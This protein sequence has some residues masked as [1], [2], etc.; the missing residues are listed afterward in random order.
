MRRAALF[1]IAAL[2]LLAQNDPVRGKEIVDKAITALGG[3][4]FL[5]M[6]DRTER[7]RAYSFYHEQLSGLSR[8]VIYTRYLTRPEPPQYGFIGLRE[9]QA[10]GKKEDVYIVF[11]EDGGH[12]ITYRGVRPLA[13]TT[14]T[15]WRESLLHNVLYILRMRLGEPGLIFEFRGTQIYENFPVSVVD[16]IDQ[17]NVVTKVYFSQ[18]SN[19]PVRQEWINRDPRT[20][21]QISEVTV[22]SKYRDIGEG[23]QWPMVIRRERDGEKVFEMFTDEISVNNGLTDD[24]FSIPTGLPM[25]DP[26]GK[27]KTKGKK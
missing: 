27:G 6:R 26:I 25:L 19:L 12:E 24:M 15:R 22:F 4:A 20:R 5:E 3:K 11:N 10:Y 17:E 1:L 18:S 16:I 7:G 21:G 9:R 14:R 2:P 8:A 23:V 13:E